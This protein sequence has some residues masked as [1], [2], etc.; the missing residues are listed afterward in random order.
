M[1]VP[2]RINIEGLFCSMFGDLFPQLK[3]SKQAHLVEYL[4][5]EYAPIIEKYSALDKHAFDGKISPIVWMFWWDG[6][7]AAVPPLVELCIKR[8]RQSGFEVRVIDKENINDYIES[9]DIV[10]LLNNG[11]IKLPF[12][13]DCIRFRLL[14]RYGGIWL[15]STIFVT[16]F[17]LFSDVLSANGF[18]SGRFPVYLDWKIVS[19]GRVSSYFLAS[20]PNHPLLSFCDD[21]FTYYMTCHKHPIDYV[22]IDYTIR[23]AYETIP[24]FKQVIDSIPYNNAQCFMLRNHINNAFDAAYWDYL[25]KETKFLKFS[26]RNDKILEDRNPHSWYDFLCSYVDNPE[27]VVSYFGDSVSDM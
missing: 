1:M 3:H 25:S 23:V 7:R 20:C 13:S 21:C 10:G 2:F 24:V 16:D 26:A 5:K 15:D 18:Y 8:M 6:L 11:R 19:R 27:K 22:Q 4:K 9:S 17:S 12:L 14:R